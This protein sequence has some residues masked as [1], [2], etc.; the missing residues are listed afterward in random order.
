MMAY[1]G[2][3]AGSIAV[4]FIPGP[5]GEVVPA[6]SDANTGE[7]LECPETIVEP[8]DSEPLISLPAIIIPAVI[9][10]AIWKGLD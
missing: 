4:R 9:S 10:A 7:P 3:G 8:D 6:C 5:N 2:A 1:A